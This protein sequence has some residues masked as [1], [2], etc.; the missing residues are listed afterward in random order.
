ME[1]A[2]FYNRWLVLRVKN[3]LNGDILEIGCG[4][5]NMTE[6]L[7]KYG[8]V[9]A[10]DIDKY[11]INRTKKRMKKLASVG[12]G[13]A[14]TGKFFFSD[15][16][17]DTVINFNV[18]EHIENDEKA[19]VNMRNRLRKGGRLVVVTPAHP[20]L[21]GSLDA[22][23]GHYRRYSKAEIIKKF[24]NAGLVVRETRYLNWLGAVGWFVNA[25]VL[26]RKILPAKQLSLYVIFSTPFLFLEKFISLPFGLSVLVVGEKP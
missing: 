11:Y 10:T 22:N 8:K 19:I 16:K 2:V 18:L 5:G 3:Y 1:K 20:T 9:T 25:R 26:R 21:F 7:A 14:E 17:F 4:I 6:L 12:Y 23:L 24:E 13:D 15:K